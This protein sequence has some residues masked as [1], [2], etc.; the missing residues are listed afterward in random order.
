MRISI[1]HVSRYTYAAPTRY[2]ILALRLTPPPFSGQRIVEWRVTAPGM[3]KARPFRDGYGNLVHLVTNTEE[4]AETL[5]I[6]EGVVQTQDKAGVV[7]GLT[8]PAP[9]RVF[10]RHTPATRVTD[11]IRELAR[12]ADGRRDVGGLHR[13]MHAVRDAI[14]YATGT[15]STRTTAAEALRQG[16]GVCQDH[17]QVFIAAARSLGIPA[18]Y[19]N[20]YLFTGANDPSAAH[21]AWAEA[22]VDGLGWVGFDVANRI[23]PTD[24]YVRL[25]TGLDAASAA[26]IRGSR[27]GVAQ[28]DLDVI[29]EVQQQSGQQQ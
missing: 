27:R 22:A 24:A 25:A 8:D 3:D 4:H 7:R 16:R 9:S 17:A 1:G 6:A 5:I 29:V 28:E 20:G 12:T 21:H 26:P 15:T 11:E 14:D 10:L 2:S 23:C 19:V 18:R 13:L